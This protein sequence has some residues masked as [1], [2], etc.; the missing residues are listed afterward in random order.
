MNR[1]TRNALAGAILQLLLLAFAVYVAIS[2]D[3]F[4]GATTAAR[5]GIV[6]IAF[7]TIFL[8][9]EVERL[10]VQVRTVT[11]LAASALGEAWLGSSRAP[12]RS[13]SR[14]WSLC[15]A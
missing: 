14:R 12:H 13:L 4:P 6:A 9:L 11:V 3:A 8:L 1:A 5:A 2:P 10:R 15:R 7:A